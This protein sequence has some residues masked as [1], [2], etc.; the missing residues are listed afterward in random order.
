MPR[1][2]IQIITSYPLHLEPVIKNRLIPFITV[3][4]KYNYSV[5]I[6]SPD[7][8]VF[9]ITGASFEHILVPDP[10]KKPKNL[11]KRM[12]FEIKQARRLINAATAFEADYKMITVPSMFLLFQMHLFKNNPVI[13]DLRDITWDYVS[14]T[15]PLFLGI[16]KIFKFLAGFNLKNSLFI[17]VT[18]ETERNY[19]INNYSLKNIEVISVPNGVTQ[20]Q[21]NQ[22]SNVTL[23]T[24]MPIKIIYIGNI[25]I[26]QNLRCFVD[27]AVKLPQIDFYIVG[28]G[29]DFASLKK[30][31]KKA[32]ISNLIMTGRLNWKEVKKMYDNAHILYAQLTP[33]FSMAMPSKLYEY[34]STGKFIIYGGDQHAKK[35]LAN[36]ENNMIIEPCSPN[37]LEDAILNLIKD[38]AYLNISTDNQ[39]KI[40]KSFIREKSAS[41]FFE[42]LNAYH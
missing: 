41:K 38:K 21:Y 6:V 24:S 5:Q 40:Q 30:Y 15:N 35:V 17:N 22:L 4:I 18:N 14:A 10:C 33:E 2:K 20:H 31:A 25:G 3:A 39:I 32:N 23:N 16:K 28:S 1:K 9:E 42:H 19:L 12:W 26:G 36:F 13:V 29:T 27:V 8:K 37:S 34:L 7:K 11:A